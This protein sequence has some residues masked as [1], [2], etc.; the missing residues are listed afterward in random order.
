MVFESGTSE[1]GDAS[2]GTS[3]QVLEQNLEKK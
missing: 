3:L 1:V 2:A